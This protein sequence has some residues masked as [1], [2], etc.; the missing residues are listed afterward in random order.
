MHFLA[1][2][3]IFLALPITGCCTAY[4]GAAYVDADESTYNYA[5]PKL[6][7]WAETKKKAGDGEWVKIVQNKNISWKARIN[8]AKKA[9]EDKKKEEKESK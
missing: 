7:E 9:A 2:L 4:P 3:A 1:L 6:V 5:A 8:R